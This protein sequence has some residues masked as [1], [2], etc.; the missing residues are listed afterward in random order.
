MSL[1]QSELGSAGLATEWRSGAVHPWLPLGGDD[2]ADQSDAAC[3][4][5]AYTC[6]VS[7]TELAGFV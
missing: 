4:R 1:S 3:A 6:A 7:A 5:T 2:D